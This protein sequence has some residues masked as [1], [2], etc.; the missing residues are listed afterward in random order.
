MYSCIYA[1]VTIAG[2]FG[3]I[4]GMLTVGQLSSF[5]S[6]TNQ[7]TKP[8]NDITSVMTE[9]QNSLASAGR[10]FELI[11]EPDAPKEPEDAAALHDPKG[12]IKISHVE[13]LLRTGKT[14]DTGPEPF[15]ASRSAYCDRR[16]Y[17][18]RK[19]NCHQ[20]SDALL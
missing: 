12:E 11:D 16:T 18:M 20:S 8:F 15:R 9:F 7:Y 5:L 4:H 13:F 2:C 1:G 10:V 17:R 3:T 6:Y 14:S 19:D